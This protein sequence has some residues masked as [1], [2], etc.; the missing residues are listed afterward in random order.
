ME[1]GGNAGLAGLRHQTAI[2]R[3]PPLPIA[4]LGKSLTKALQSPELQEFG[5][6]RIMPIH[7]GINFFYE[8]SLIIEDSEI[9]FNNFKGI[10]LSI[11]T[12]WSP[13][14]DFAESRS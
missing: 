7:S 4:S 12:R 8:I 3:Y 5:L 11:F 14:K 1:I 6:I 2:P 10:F 9:K 13:G